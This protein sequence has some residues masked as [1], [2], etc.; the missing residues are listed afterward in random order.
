[1][2]VCLSVTCG[3][4]TDTESVSQ[5]RPANSSTAKDSRDWVAATITLVLFFVTVGRVPMFEM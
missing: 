3:L 5:D 4:R 1:M 2:F